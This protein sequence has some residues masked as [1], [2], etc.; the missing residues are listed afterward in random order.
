MSHQP[1]SL[2]DMGL[3]SKKNYISVKPVAE[4]KQRQCMITWNI[5]SISRKKLK[6][7]EPLLEMGCRLRKNYILVKPVAEP[8]QITL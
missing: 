5:M 7:V 4:S 3:Q 6:I 2:P 1:G 8:K